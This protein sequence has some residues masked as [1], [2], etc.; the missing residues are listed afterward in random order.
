LLDLEITAIKTVV[1]AI[2]A[3]TDN[4]PSDPADA[5]VIAGWLA[6]IPADV[7]NVAISEGFPAERLMRVMAAILA[8]KT[9]TN[10]TVIRDV[11]DAEDMVS[12]T[13]EGSNRTAVTIGS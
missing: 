6:T 9:N 10:G 12:V 3:K 4:L 8:G 7:W 2:Q 1:D 13:I 11:T 5:S